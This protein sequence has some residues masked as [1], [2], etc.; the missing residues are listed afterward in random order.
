MQKIQSTQAATAA[1]NLAAMASQNPANPP[2]RTSEEMVRV[3]MTAPMQK[4]EVNELPGFW[5]QWIRGTP[6]RMMQAKRA[7]F[8]H[9]HELELTINNHD[10]GGDAKTSGNTDLGT[11]VSTTDGSG[12]IGQDGQGVRLYLMKQRKEHHDE[13]TAILQARNDSVVDSLTAAFRQ[14]TVGVGAEGAPSETAH[15]VQQRYVK[16]D[17][18]IPEIFRRK[19][20]KA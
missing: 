13:D 1:E 19:P 11:I 18:R 20:N 7:G 16:P 4:L 17:L 10:L 8:T 5:M 3:P 15:D 2:D 6:D 14:G 9:V 12:E